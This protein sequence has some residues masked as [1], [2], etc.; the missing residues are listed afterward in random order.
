MDS[1][2]VG[3]S[4]ASG[5]FEP[6]SWII[7]AGYWAP[8]SHTYVKFYLK[9]LDMNIIVQASGL[10][11]NMVSQALFD[12]QEI[13]YKEFTFPISEDKKKAFVQF[14][15]NQS[16]KPY[17]MVG[18]LGMVWVR[19]GQLLGLKTKS[20]FNY[21][22]SS[23]FCSELVGYVL[24]NYENIEFGENVADLSPKDVYNVLIKT[25]VSS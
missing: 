6:F 18:I 7:M 16:G 20:P 4:R 19:I 5:W 12:Q 10:K 22:G 3:F 9:E 23:D 11:V 24:E 8:F 14:A 17:N 25:S 21:N 15:F 2:T 13:V 1:I